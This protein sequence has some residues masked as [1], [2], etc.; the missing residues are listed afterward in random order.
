MDN[1]KKERLKSQKKAGAKRKMLSKIDLD[2]KFTFLTYIISIFDHNIYSKP[3][4]F[5]SNDTPKMP[6]YP[7]FMK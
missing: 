4:H 6:S 7:N 1:N 2:I 5:R 3:L